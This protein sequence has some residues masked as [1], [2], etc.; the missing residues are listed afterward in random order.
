MTAD[1]R[2]S[3]ETTART[4]VGRVRK[5]NE[6]SFLCDAG[7]GLFAV[8]DG[9]GGEKAGEVAAEIA[10]EALLKVPDLVMAV[11]IANDRMLQRGRERPEESGM[12]CVLSAARVIG[13]RLEI[14]HV[15]DTRAYLASAAGC[16]QLTRDHTTV[17]EAQERLGLTAV[18]ARRV[19]GRHLVTR[20][21]GRESHAN[22]RWI[23]RINADFLRDDLLL[24]SSDGLHDLVED[25]DLRAILTEARRMGEPVE[26]LG[27]RLEAMALERGGYDN[28]SL[29]MV[30]QRAERPWSRVRRIFADGGK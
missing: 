15:G 4:H 12:G 1:L 17:A 21:V 9:M 3:L 18:Q 10:R 25:A 19:A 14:V 24:L 30:R 29:V 28:I 20:D 6:D 5:H 11:Q 13:L 2:G 27:A 23:D 16:E 7:R 8:I 22:D 26:E